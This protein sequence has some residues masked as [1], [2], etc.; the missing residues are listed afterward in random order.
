MNLIEFCRLQG[1]SFVGKGIW[2]DLPNQYPIEV[3]IPEASRSDDLYRRVKEW[4]NNAYHNEDFVEIA[5]RYFFKTDTD[6]M[7]FKLAW[8]L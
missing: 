7:Q 5:Y 1:A 6:A 3:Q 2:P 4:T 8:C